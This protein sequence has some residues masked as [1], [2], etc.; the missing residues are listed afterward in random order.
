[1]PF[2]ACPNCGRHFHLQVSKIEKWFQERHPNLP[3]GEIPSELCYN[4]WVD[5]KPLQEVYI[6]KTQKAI[7][8][9]T[10]EDLGVIINIKEDE[11]GEKLFEVRLNDNTLHEFRREMITSSRFLIQ[12]S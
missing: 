6:I 2:V 12:N 9:F 4:C 5:L 7:P 11:T 3:D 1:M 10:A 8:A